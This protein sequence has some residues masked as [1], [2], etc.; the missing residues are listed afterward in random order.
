[1]NRIE[2]RMSF[3]RDASKVLG[4]NLFVLII[5]FT[6][7]IV[8]ARTLGPEGKGL[9]AAV[10]VYPSLFIGLAEMGIRQATVYFIGNKLYK[11]HEIISALYLLLIASSCLGILLCVCIFIAIHNA[12]FSVPMI[13]L[14]LMVIPLQLMVSYSSGVFL[15]KGDIGRFSNVQWMCEMVKLVL[16]VVLVWWMRVGV[17]GG[18]ISIV[19]GNCLVAFYAIWL[20][21]K[22]APIRVAFNSKLVKSML[23]MGVVYA[24]SLFI[25]QMNYRLD[26]A[27]MERLST[28]SEIGQYTLG[29]STVELLWQLPSALGIV[30]FS[31]SS[32][33]Q[34]SALFSRSVCKLLRVSFVAVVLGS[35]IWILLSR[36]M[37]T[38]VYGN[39][40]SPSVDVVRLLTPGIIAFTVV[41]VLNM[42]LAGRGKPWVVLY[43][44]I[45]S[46][47]LNATLNFFWIPVHGAKGAACASACS[48]SLAGIIFLVM[49]AKVVK[50]PIREVISYR[51]SDFDFILQRIR[52]RQ[53]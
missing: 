38:L 41:K 23:K 3:I 16:A 27:L 36:F 42:D 2:K 39:A 15:G 18:L 35:A 53:Q 9:L 32:N 48:Y 40:F 24:I 29:V 7:G 1:M 11:E 52:K 44:A 46:L 28:A 21:A 31:R 4:S 20:V 14:A 37:I 25:L 51:K 8:L 34:D 5:T 26:I 33:A 10:L 49:Y 43:A 12:K 6:S 17:V 19:A 30:V 22:I 47:V 13:L 50:L 45:P